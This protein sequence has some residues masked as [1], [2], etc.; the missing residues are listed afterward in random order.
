MHIILTGSFVRSPRYM[1]SNFVDALHICNWIGFPSLFITFTGNPQWIEIQM[2]LKS[3]CLRTE[4]RPDLI[5]RVFKMK[6]D[7]ML[8]DFKKGDIFAKIRARK[9]HYSYFSYTHINFCLHTLKLFVK[10]FFI[11]IAL[12]A[13]HYNLKAIYLNL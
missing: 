13:L 7:L 4:D 8:K 2:E 6:L 3:T 5:C 11:S 9:N 12:F 1:F 10:N